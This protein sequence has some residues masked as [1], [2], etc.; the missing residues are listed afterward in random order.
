MSMTVGESYTFFERRKGYFYDWK[1]IVYSLTQNGDE[2]CYEIINFLHRWTFRESFINNSSAFS[3]WVLRDQDT[4][5]SVADRLYKSP[6]YFWI[7]LMFNN[8][9]DPIY[10]FPMTD[11]QLLR[12]CELK[13]GVDKVNALHHYEAGASGE[14]RA[15]VPGTVVSADYPYT[16]VKV[17]NHEYEDRLNHKR[18]YVKLMKPGYL[19]AV[20][21]EQEEIVK[22]DFIEMRR[23]GE[24]YIITE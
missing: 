13:Y 15:L 9:C 22:S 12:F 10:S 3:Y 14:I 16:K 2:R 6:Y 21:K 17:S 1:K 18:R 20:L 11:Q 4:L 8:L 23:R 7:I 19:K 24:Q 5:F